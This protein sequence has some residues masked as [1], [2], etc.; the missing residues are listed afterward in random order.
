[1]AFGAVVF[2]AVWYAGRRLRLRSERDCRLRRE[3]QEEA[4]RIVAEERA[5]IARELHDVVAH[6]V[7]LMT[8]QAGRPRPSQQATRRPQFAPWPRGGR[9]AASPGRA[10]DLLGVLRPTS[11]PD[12]M[13]PQPGL[14]ELDPLVRQTRQAGVDVSL[15][16]SGSLTDLPARV[17]LSA[18][19]IVQES[20]TNV[21][22]HAGPGARTCVRLTNDAAR[23]WSR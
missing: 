19:R 2:F 9:R 14:A 17:E 7:S 6:R 21:V 1:V 23:C 18:Y 16:T 13:Q 15:T 10:A 20:L 12:A 4:E 8:V 22:K 3:Q 11:E 5:R